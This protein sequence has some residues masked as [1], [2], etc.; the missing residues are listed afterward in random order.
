[1]YFMGL[2]C[3][4]MDG[5]PTMG[6]INIM[7]TKTNWKHKKNFVDPE[8]KAMTQNIER[9]WREVKKNVQKYGK[10]KGYPHQFERIQFIFRFKSH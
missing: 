4:R 2:R 1:M 10:K 9:I 7:A 8:M 5:L 3:R 6:S